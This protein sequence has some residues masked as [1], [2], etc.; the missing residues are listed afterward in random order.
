[1]LVYSRRRPSGRLVPRRA[2]ALP[3]APTRALLHTGGAALP[4]FQVSSLGQ[5]HLLS[6]P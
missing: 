3:P 1:M 6:E 2:A 4:A 5:V